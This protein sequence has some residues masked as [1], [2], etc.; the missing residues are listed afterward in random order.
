MGAPNP[1]TTLTNTPEFFAFLYPNNVVNSP[2][3]TINI[4]GKW[5]FSND[6]NAVL[7]TWAGTDDDGNPY[8]ESAN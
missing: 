5:Q 6:G 4:S 7:A 1:F 2:L 3:R 8:V